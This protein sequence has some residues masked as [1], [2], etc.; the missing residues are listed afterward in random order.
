ML[1]KGWIRIRITAEDHI[2]YSEIEF[3]NT[4]TEA[5]VL[6]KPALYSD[7]EPR[8]EQGSTRGLTI[9]KISVTPK[10]RCTH[11]SPCTK[12]PRSSDPFYIVSYYLK[13]ATTS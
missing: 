2:V 13:W 5:Q 3:G 12:C 9:G 4:I 1:L 11:W 10:I 6:V 7:T 8:G